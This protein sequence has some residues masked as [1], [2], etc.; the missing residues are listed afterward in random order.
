[1]LDTPVRRYHGTGF[2]SRMTSSPGNCE[3]KT[4]I[5]HCEKGR[6]EECCNAA[7]E[8]NAERSIKH[9]PQS[10][11][12]R[13][14]R[15]FFP[16]TGTGS[17]HNDDGGGARN[18]LR[19]TFLH[20]FFLQRLPYPLP[21]KRV[22]PPKPPTN[23]NVKMSSSLN[24]A[25]QQQHL[26]MT[27]TSSSSFRTVSSEEGA[28]SDN[29]VFQRSTNILA[30]RK[31]S[32]ISTTTTTTTTDKPSVCK[33]D[34]FQ[35]F[36]SYLTE[37]DTDSIK[38]EDLHAVACD[39][40]DLVVF[41]SKPTAYNDPSIVPLHTSEFRTTDI[42]KPVQSKTFCYQANNLLSIRF[43]CGCEQGNREHMEDYYVA[44][45]NLLSLKVDS[46][47]QPQATVQ[48]EEG[49]EQ[50]T[51]LDDDGTQILETAAFFAVYDGHNGKYVAK[52]LHKELHHC[53]LLQPSF[54]SE[55]TTALENACKE[56]DE[57]YLIAQSMHLYM[58]N[59]SKRNINNG[60]A[61]RSIE[62]NW[63][64][65]DKTIFSSKWN[66]KPHF[67]QVVRDVYELCSKEEKLGGAASFAGSAAVIAILYRPASSI[68]RSVYLLI[69]NV[70]DCRA[71]LCSKNVAM[72]LSVDQI[73]GRKS[74][75]ERI[76]AANGF[77]NHER[78]NGMLGAFCILADRMLLVEI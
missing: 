65:M 41:N 57:A 45:G 28:E 10:P 56:V 54:P 1:M 25:L 22:E 14:N 50:T 63:A 16:P 31:I 11:L 76:L 8:F 32:N 6:V 18:G 42:R 36:H 74:E 69:A 47:I 64:K 9:E 7:A 24:G 67:S 2:L 23:G 61:T 75:R 52:T 33:V 3:F 78:L 46:S 58:K 39:D 34:S 77:I 20:N 60:E 35:T 5:I 51:L 70:G 66:C 4:D 49:E 17:E 15:Y 19:T 43:G 62:P 21:P 26:L 38:S 13:K 55:M 71:V 37:E 40:L 72:A 73:P 48:E 27:K 29:A 59:N 44:I 53:L 68:D 30:L 12:L